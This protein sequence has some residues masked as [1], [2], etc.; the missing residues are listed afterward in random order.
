MKVVD[1][2]FFAVSDPLDTLYNNWSRRYEYPW[3]FSR[4]MAY[5]AHTVHNTACGGGFDVHKQFMERL[6]D[7][8]EV[9]HSD[10]EELYCDESVYFDITK[11]IDNPDKINCFDA[12]VCVSAI[13]HIPN[14]K[15]I[16][17]I[18]NL[19][20]QLKPGGV[21]L[22]TFDAPPVNWSELTFDLQH[23]CRMPD[24]V[25]LCFEPEYLATKVIRLEIIK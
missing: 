4:L 1:F 8:Y 9:V 3:V 13:E 21:L 22:I 23:E 24:D 15:P 5:G 10:I 14:V 20:E 6:S 7:N 2:S 25:L 19:M 11:P 18:K 12:V 16:T 17:I